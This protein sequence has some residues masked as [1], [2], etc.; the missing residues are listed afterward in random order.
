MKKI[1]ALSLVLVLAVFCFAAC[2]KETPANTEKTYTLALAVD[3]TIADD[4]KVTNYVTALVL[5]ENNKIVAVRI[6]CI[7]T[8]PELEN[9]AIKDVVSVASKVAQGENYGGATSYA[10]MKSGSFAK[11]TAAFE[12]AIVGKSADEVANL[13]LSLVAGCTMPYSPVSFKAVIAKA[14]ASDNKTTFKT[15]ES[16]TLGLAADMSVS[17]GKVTTYYTGIAVVGGKLAASII[18]CGEVSFTV[19]GD[20]IIAGEYNG[21][22][23]ELGENYGGAT[24][25]AP[26]K[27]GSFAKQTAAFEDAIVGKT[28]DEVASLDLSLVAGCTMPYSP[29]SFKV[30][31]AQA[32]TNAR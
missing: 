12:A 27:S 9:G 20:A 7:E 26:M 32:F 6:D 2:T 11:Q 21:T 13:D 14:F 23:V 10:P 28:A 22:K 4:N 16:F 1:I 5:D 8:T 29:I 31:L 19:D 3:T 24:S 30:V 18:D 15:S 25:Y 17:G